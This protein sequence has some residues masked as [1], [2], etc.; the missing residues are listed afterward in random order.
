MFAGEQDASIV[1]V[2]LF[3]SFF[4][5]SSLLFFSPDGGAGSSLSSSL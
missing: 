1:N 2:P 5:V 4:A 3:V